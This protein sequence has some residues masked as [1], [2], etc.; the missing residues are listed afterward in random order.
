MF[1]IRF[2]GRGG[3]GMK[4]ASRIVGTAAFRQG[5]YAQDSPVYG[6]E[7]RGAPMTAFTRIDAQPIL[8]RGVVVLPDLIVIADATLLD[9]PIVR[10]L[11]GLSSGGSVLVN[12]N[13]AIES[14]VTC[15]FTTLALNHVGSTSALSVALGA[16]AAKLAGLNLEFVEQAIREE[17]EALRL[18]PVRLEKNLAL[19]RACFDAVSSTQ[20]APR[21]QTSQA[22]AEIHVVTPT[23]E[24]AW[25]GCPSVASAPNTQLRKT[26]KWRV[27]RPVINAERCTDCWICF[28]NCP[29]G[30]IGL[31]S[32]DAP[33]IDYAVCK[34]CMIC[35]AECPISA[36][37][38]V[39]EAE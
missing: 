22:S 21:S 12:S 27:M 29:D 30:A 5:Y 4:T 3:Q 35:A 9:D 23:Y 39:R 10:P 37:E 19:A 38:T 15:D 7:R 20:D 32:G 26:G 16:G 31:G 33:H 11:Y 36:I 1:R 13:R 8:E 14:A 2:H 34:G 25:T 18:D 17:L 6:A 28:L 24:G